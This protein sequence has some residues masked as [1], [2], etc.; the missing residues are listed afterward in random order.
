M[1]KFASKAPLF[2]PLL[3]VFFVFHRW[4]ENR[5]FVSFAD[6]LPLLGI[7][8]AAAMALY[9][10]FFL[11]LRNSGRAAIV[12]FY[13]LGFYLFF[14]VFHD[15]LRKNAIFLHRYSLLLPLFLVSVIVLAL[16]L[17]KRTGF[18]RIT[19][20][21]NTLLVAYLLVDLATWV[22][23]PGGR[24]PGASTG[25]ALMRDY[26]ACDSCAQPDIYLLVF[27][28]YSA[29]QT[30]RNEFHYDNSGLDSFL[31]QQGFHIL[32]HS[33]S[34]YYS[35]AFSMA[36]I[37]NMSYIQGIPQPLNL[38]P[39]DYLTAME[40]IRSSVVVNFLI[41]RGYAIVNNSPFDL[42][43]HPL[44]IDQPFIPAKTRLITYS[45]LH[46]YLRRDLGYVLDKLLAGRRS[47]LESNIS[48]VNTLNHRFLEETIAESGR[49][50][51]RPRFVYMH[52]L[53]P[54]LPYFYDSL[55]HPRPMA[56]IEQN[57][58]KGSPSPYLAYLPYTNARIRELITAIRRNTAGKA[59]ILF[60]SDHG[61]RYDPRD[62]D[63]PWFF[64]NQ[65]AVY[66]PDGDPSP[67]YDSISGVNQFRVLFNKMFRLN[68]PLLKDSTLFLH[69]RPDQDPTNNELK[70]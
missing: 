69:D 27:D 50:D 2:V 65:N 46:D 48:I 21:L 51:T 6:C 62:Q 3:P 60:M 52:V 66:V 44:K 43:G 13:V 70:P 14:G 49:K 5:D 34:N 61:F 25:A 28:E 15:L 53:M 29:N 9:F 47:V 17:R 19:L 38:Q 35:T 37:L 59:V 1:K 10:I 11:I 58:R 30:L 45:T 68:L 22:G 18:T 64:Y 20:F 33:R 36:S 8:L 26:P 39:N 7:Y 55:L 32:T 42:P 67:F 16:Q 4:V 23:R 12:T 40:R 41:A 56:E 24:R 57:L 31:R 63:R 54:H